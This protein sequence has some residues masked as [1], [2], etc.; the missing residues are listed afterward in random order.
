MAKL[1]IIVEGK[2]DDISDD[3]INKVRDELY[4][5]M[6]LRREMYQTNEYEV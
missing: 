6:C 5:F 3:E 1:K 4:K 2:L